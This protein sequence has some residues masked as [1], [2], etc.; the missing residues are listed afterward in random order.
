[1]R[2]KEQDSLNSRFHFPPLEFCA[3]V[4]DGHSAVE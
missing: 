1:M 2:G 4:V 3:S